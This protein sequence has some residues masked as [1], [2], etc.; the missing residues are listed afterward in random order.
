M[1][2]REE[3]GVDIE[4]MSSAQLETLLADVEKQLDK[5]RERERKEV[6]KQLQDTAK[7]AGFELEDFLNPGSG[8][9]S[10]QRRQPTP[11]KYCNPADPEQTWT[12]KGK[13]PGWFDEIEQKYVAEGHEFGKSARNKAKEECAIEKFQDKNADA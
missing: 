5:T 4:R 7:A 6:L 9:R 3:H 12:G 13:R 2:D 8:H 10:G 1:V 11:P